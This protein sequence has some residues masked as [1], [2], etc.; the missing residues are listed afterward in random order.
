MEIITKEMAMVLLEIEVKA[1]EIL[2]VHC[3]VKVEDMVDLT[4]VQM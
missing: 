4:K 1:K 2:E 3:M